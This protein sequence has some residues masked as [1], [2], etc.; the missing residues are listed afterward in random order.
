MREAL[1]HYTVVLA[2]TLQQSAGK[3]MRRVRGIE[4]GQTSFESVIVDE[5]ARANPL[6]LFIPLSMAKR[7]VV[8]VGDHRQ[9]PH[10]LEPDVERQLA[11]GVDQGTV[12]AQTL[13]AV[14]ASLFERLWVV[15]RK[16]EQRDGIRRTVTL[17]AQYRMHP[18]LGRF[19]SRE[20]YE[21]H[22]D[23][24]IESPRRADEFRPRPCRPLPRPAPLRIVERRRRRSRPARSGTPARS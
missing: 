1:Q 15:L 8:L 22:D 2:A 6:D 10:L 23:G 24:E 17:N 18:E 19:V 4:E 16:L 3:E 12:A 7:R 21:I 11:E 20:F 13:H 9:L 14:Q 5:A